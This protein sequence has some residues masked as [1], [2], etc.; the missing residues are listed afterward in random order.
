MTRE[1]NLPFEAPFN[2]NVQHRTYPCRGPP[3]P[4]P[5]HHH[6]FQPPVVWKGQI[7]SLGR[8]MTRDSRLPFEA[9]INLNVRT[10]RVPAN[11]K[12]AP[13]QPLRNLQRPVVRTRQIRS[14]GRRQGL[15]V[16]F[17][18]HF[19]LS[20]SFLSPPKGPEVTVPL[21]VVHQSQIPPLG[22]TKVRQIFTRPLFCQQRH[23]GY[24]HFQ[25]QCLQLRSR[26]EFQPQ[27]AQDSGLASTYRVTK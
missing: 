23:R 25:A 6:N 18:K 12:P 7:R 9:P 16:C 2:L 15:Q 17:V 8:E 10:C 19:F 4:N 1:W 3:T 14:R 22:G 11:L 20:R 27:C 13:P 24:P 26:P 21:L 5:Q